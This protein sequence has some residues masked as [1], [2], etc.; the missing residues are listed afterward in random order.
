MQGAGMIGHEV[1]SN[2]Y[3]TFVLQQSMGGGKVDYELS[4][5]AHAL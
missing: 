2:S 3:Q 4:G 1:F 5:V